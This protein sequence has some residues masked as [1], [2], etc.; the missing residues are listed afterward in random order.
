MDM[1]CAHEMQVIIAKKLEKHFSYFLFSDFLIDYKSYLEAPKYTV[2][3]WA[4]RA[5]GTN[6]Y[7]INDKYEMRSARNYMENRMTE[8]GITYY[9]IRK[10]VA[11][12]E[13]DKEA[14]KEILEDNV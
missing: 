8:T 10:D 1:D 11:I 9:L 7:N 2:W 4:V 12:K 3:F 6:M 5:S 13:M 14:M